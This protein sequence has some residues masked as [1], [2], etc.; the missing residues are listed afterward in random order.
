MDDQRRSRNALGARRGGTRLVT[1]GGGEAMRLPEGGT[2]SIRQR[3]TASVAAAHP[4][5]AEITVEARIE[6][7]SADGE[8]VEVEARNSV[9]RDHVIHH[10]RVLVDGLPLLERTWSNL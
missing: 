2:F 3:A 9:R 10:G 6:T 1:L 8:L 4:E 5:G 7:R